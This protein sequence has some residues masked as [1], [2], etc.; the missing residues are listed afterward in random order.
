MEYTKLSD[1]TSLRIKYSAL[2]AVFIR[3]SVFR[4]CARWYVYTVFYS[5][6]NIS[7]KSYTAL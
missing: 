6:D 4:H 7:N 3:N 5:S 1:D 2:T